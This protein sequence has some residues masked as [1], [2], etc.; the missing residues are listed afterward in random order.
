MKR[1]KTQRGFAYYEFTDAYGAKCSLQKSSSAMVDRIWFGVDDADPKIM[2][3]KTPEG[4]NGWVPY[5][6]PEDVMLTTRMHLD[7]KQ[8]KKLLPILQRFVETGEITE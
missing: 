4:G 5:T 8:V 2:A 1:K 7:Q 6:I 3:S